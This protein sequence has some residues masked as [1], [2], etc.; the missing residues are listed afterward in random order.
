[1]RRA[2]GT[3]SEGSVDN[4]LTDA[5]AGTEAHA[6]GALDAVR[7]WREEGSRL[8]ESLERQLAEAQQ[9]VIDATDRVRVIQEALDE[10]KPAPTHMRS[11]RAVS[12]QYNLL[13]TGDHADAQLARARATGLSATDAI[14][15][16][17]EMNPGGL[18][19]SASHEWLSQLR[20]GISMKNVHTYVHRLLQNQ[21]IVGR[22]PKGHRVYVLKSNEDGNATR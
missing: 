2:N 18:N 17:L 9:A 8:R 7:R 15:M 3:E 10:I 4:Q 1:M 22:G 14:I 16:A 5:A 11:V 19:A 13:Y 21:K 6:S 20:R 12:P